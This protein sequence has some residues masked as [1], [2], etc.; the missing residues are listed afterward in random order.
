MIISKYKIVE[1]HFKAYD[2]GIEIESLA[3]IGILYAKIE[4][5]KSNIHVFNLHL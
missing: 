1:S 4:L 2:N 3:N 5:P